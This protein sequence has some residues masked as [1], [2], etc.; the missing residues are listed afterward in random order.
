MRYRDILEEEVKRIEDCFN[1]NELA[2]LALT[3]KVEF[4]IRDKLAYNLYK[5]LKEQDIIVSREWR[6]SDL[7]FLYSG[8]PIFICELKAAYTFD[9]FSHKAYLDLIEK[10]I[11]KAKAI[12]TPQT[13]IASL[14][15]TTHVHQLVDNRFNKVIKYHTGI[16]N[17]L[18]KHVSQLKMMETAMEIM[19]NGFVHFDVKDGIIKCGK[20][21]EYDVEI[22]YWIFSERNNDK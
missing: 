2:Y 3:S 8:Q 4:P 22:Y 9:I 12:S 14:F 18:K 19:G 11:A 13:E 21:F 7:A 10:D 20:A 15:L 16:N 1:E 17:A 6:R 5:R